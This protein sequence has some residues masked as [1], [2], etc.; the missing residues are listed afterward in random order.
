MEVH[1]NDSLQKEALK[2][3][4]RS[5]AAARVMVMQ[6]RP[7]S[8]S[9]LHFKAACRRPRANIH[10]LLS[11]SNALCPLRDREEIK[12]ILSWRFLLCRHA[13]STSVLHEKIMILKLK[14]A[15]GID[16]FCMTLYYILYSYDIVFHNILISIFI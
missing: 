1:R 15:S 6:F 16:S 3:Q 13:F 8:S 11:G 9:S 12:E 10:S 4:E 7:S 14:N 5:Y 2:I